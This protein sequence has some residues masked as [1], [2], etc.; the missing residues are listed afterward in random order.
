VQLEIFA[1]WNGFNEGDRIALK[2]APLD[3]IATI[4]K[5]TSG[6]V[7]LV[8]DTHPKCD[9]TDFPKFRFKDLFL[10]PELEAINDLG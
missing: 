6:K 5:I 10:K 8:W 2:S 7:L 4:T 3:V 1:G 9:P